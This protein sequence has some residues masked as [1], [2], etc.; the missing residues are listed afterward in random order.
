MLNFFRK[1][2]PEI[3]E[4][5]AIAK[6]PALR[7]GLLQ[8]AEVKIKPYV[9]KL[10]VAIKNLEV[11]T[12]EL[13]GVDLHS[14]EIGGKISSCA[15]GGCAIPGLSGSPD[16][17]TEQV[18]ANKER[19][20]E[21]L[22]QFIGWLQDWHSKL[23]SSKFTELKTKVNLFDNRLMKF[24]HATRKNFVVLTELIGKEAEQVLYF[25]KKIIGL[26]K[27]MS[28]KLRK[29]QV[30]LIVEIDFLL[31]AIDTKKNS[32]MKPGQEAEKSTQELADLRNKLK[33][34]QKQAEGIGKEDI[35]KL[36]KAREE[37]DATQGALRR[38][39]ERIKNFFSFHQKGLKKI[40]HAE[41]SK[42][43]LFY[44]QDPC[45]AL[46]LDN[47]LAIMDLFKKLK[48]ELEAGHLE[49]KE[50]TRK[51]L[52]NRLKDFY[53]I[54]LLR[55]KLIEALKRKEEVEMNEKKAQESDGIKAK[56][57]KEKEIESIRS[58]LR[59]L[60]NELNKQLLRKDKLV[61]EVERKRKEAKTKIK[62]LNFY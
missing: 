3:K 5:E 58:E 59:K 55:Q 37:K 56:L 47:D 57:A 33:E 40:L 42:K 54:R 32:L 12:K 62:N 13:K 14:R 43:L 29:L 2:R 15:R 45:E 38:Q 28:L 30:P 44:L 39:E 41:P 26:S 60:Q 6:W 16:K 1:R 27:A 48:Q 50:K 23:L 46:L 61:A 51:V 53:K 20:V 52:L 11:K 8:K 31:E 18:E 22:S 9:R 10:G 35:K 36:E 24:S 4:G 34:K 25:L 7:K 17:I 49:L 19:Y 21:Q